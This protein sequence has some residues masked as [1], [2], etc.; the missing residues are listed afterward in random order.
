VQSADQQPRRSQTILMSKDE[1]LRDDGA[2]EE[3][4]KL[5]GPMTRD[6]RSRPP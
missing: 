4:T 2:D 6:A 1:T 5:P 3:E